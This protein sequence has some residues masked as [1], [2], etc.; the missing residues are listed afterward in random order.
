MEKGRQELLKK[1]PTRKLIASIKRD[2]RKMAKATAST[3]KPKKK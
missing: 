3:G 2:M 1:V